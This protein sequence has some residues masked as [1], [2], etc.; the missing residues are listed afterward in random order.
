MQST[1]PTEK[2]DRTFEIEINGKAVPCAEAHITRVL[3]ED[4]HKEIKTFYEK[5]SAE[6]LTYAEKTLAPEFAECFKNAQTVRERCSLKIPVLCVSVT[7]SGE[8]TLTVTT[9]YTLF[10]G[11]RAEKRE[12]IRTDWDADRGIM[13]KKR[14]NKKGST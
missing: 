11:A 6:F 5:L 8:E 4:V 3:P 2:T 14:A 13:V 12:E 9:A 1:V 7:A 10:C